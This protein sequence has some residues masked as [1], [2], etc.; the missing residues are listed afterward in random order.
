MREKI[1]FKFFVLVT[2]AAVL[3]ASGC[4]SNTAKMAY[5][6]TRQVYNVCVDQFL[7]DFEM[8]SEETKARYK[9]DLVPAM[10]DAYKALDAWGSVVN[11]NQDPTIALQD[12]LRAK[13]ELLI[14]GAKWFNRL[15]DK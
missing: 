5:V 12:W 1:N 4:A 11:A 10:I 15:S 13:N 2:I 14:Y 8:S 9:Q 3:I 6:N 7:V